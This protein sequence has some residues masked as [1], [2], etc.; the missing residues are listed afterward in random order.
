MKVF[1]LIFF[2]MLVLF[3]VS[4]SFQGSVYIMIVW[5]ETIGRPDGVFTHNIPGVP[6]AP[7]VENG[8]YYK[9]APGSFG[10]TSVSYVAPPSGPAGP[11]SLTYTFS[12]DSAILGIEDAYYDIRILNNGNPTVKKVPSSSY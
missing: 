11:F 5:D 1:T 7:A 6:L 3:G 2:I 12:A 8:H 9:S 4:C 10:I